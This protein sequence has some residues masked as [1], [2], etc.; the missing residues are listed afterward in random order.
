LPKPLGNLITNHCLFSQAWHFLLQS[1][2]QNRRRRRISVSNFGSKV[3][4]N[5]RED[6]RGRQKY[7][8]RRYQEKESV[9]QVKEW[10]EV[11]AEEKMLLKFE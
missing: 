11:E 10:A 1:Q 4:K 7:S 3:F 9:I 6:E 2:R 5:L 8:S